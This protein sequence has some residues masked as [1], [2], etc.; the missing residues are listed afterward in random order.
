[1]SDESSRAQEEQE[2]EAL[3]RALEGQGT[4]APSDALEIAA[5]LRYARG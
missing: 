5:L 1:M 4:D 3:A 2:A